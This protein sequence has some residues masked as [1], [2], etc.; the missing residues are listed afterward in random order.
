[1]G[2]ITVGD[3]ITVDLIAKLELSEGKTKPVKFK[4]T[5]KR[6]PINEFKEDLKAADAGTLSDEEMVRD[7]LTDWGMPGE[8]GERVEFNEENVNLALTYREYRRELVRGIF[9]VNDGRDSLA[10]KNL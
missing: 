7:Y 5:I 6:K 8:D 2:L 10:V 1:M 3:R 9:L 4:A